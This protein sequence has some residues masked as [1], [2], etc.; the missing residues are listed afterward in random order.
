MVKKLLL[1][2]ITGLL[3]VSIAFVGV[4]ELTGNSLFRGKKANPIAGMVLELTVPIFTAVTDNSRTKTCIANQREIVSQITTY[5]MSYN[6][7][8]S[9]NIEVYS[10]GDYAYDVLSDM[11]ELDEYTF[12]SLFQ[13]TPYCPDGGTYQIAVY[14]DDYSYDVQVVCSEHGSYNSDY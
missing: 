2:F 5:F 6:L 8:D 12:E 11:Y 9:G 14:S 1:G 3:V 4:A 10:D 13:I 7:S